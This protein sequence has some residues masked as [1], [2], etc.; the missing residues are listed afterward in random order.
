MKHFLNMI[1][2]LDIVMKYLRSFFVT[3]TFQSIS[4]RMCKINKKKNVY[5]ANLCAYNAMFMVVNN[6]LGLVL[7]SRFH[8]EL[9]KKLLNNQKTLKYAKI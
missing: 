3:P 5:S 4:K 8:N 6:F 9:C 7:S 2:T 1:I